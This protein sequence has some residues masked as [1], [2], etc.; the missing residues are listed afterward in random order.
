MVGALLSF[1]TDPPG[2]IQKMVEQA[3]KLTGAARSV[4]GTVRRQRQAAGPSAGPSEGLPVLDQLPAVLEQVQ[5]LANAAVEIAKLVRTG[6][7]GA[8]AQY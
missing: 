4:M 2:A 3:G 6:N 5:R 7:R 8:P 1:F